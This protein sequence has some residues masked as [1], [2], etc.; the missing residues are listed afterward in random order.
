VCRYVGTYELILDNSDLWGCFKIKLKFRTEWGIVLNTTTSFIFHHLD[1]ECMFTYIRGRSLKGSIF[2]GTQNKRRKILS[3]QKNTSDN[4]VEILTFWWVVHLKG[5]NTGDH[6]KEMR[7]QP[8]LSKDISVC[9][10]ETTIQQY[11]CIYRLPILKF[12]FMG[13]IC[14]VAGKTCI[15]TVVGFW[16][17]GTLTELSQEYNKHFVFSRATYIVCITFTRIVHTTSTLPRTETT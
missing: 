1:E 11:I 10:F 6:V 16:N 8:L 13:S 14:R 7:D 5:G 2:E 4:E 17:H 9:W 3:S 15:G 12:N